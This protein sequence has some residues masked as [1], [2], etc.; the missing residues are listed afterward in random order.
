MRKLF[1]FL[2]FIPN[3]LIGQNVDKLI[4]EVNDYDSISI[5]NNIQILDEFR[6]KELRI[7][8]LTLSNLPGSAGFDNG[9]VTKNLFIAISEFDEFPEQKLYVI[10]NLYGLKIVKI[11]KSNERPFVTFSFIKDSKIETLNIELS[12][13]EIRIIE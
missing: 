3:L 13:K 11:E 6:T 8:F 4:E 7:R 1:I 5:F 10:K 12:L 9:E 2:I